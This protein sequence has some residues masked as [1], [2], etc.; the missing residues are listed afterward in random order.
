LTLA[1]DHLAPDLLIWRT[2]LFYPD[3]VVVAG[4]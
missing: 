1:V 4:I 2:T 3:Q